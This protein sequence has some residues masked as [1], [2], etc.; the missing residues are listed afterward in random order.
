MVTVYS[1]KKKSLI[2]RHSKT[3]YTKI[4]TLGRKNCIMSL[5]RLQSQRVLID[6]AIQVHKLDSMPEIN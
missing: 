3:L 6:K 5:Q 1:N 4:R 2:E